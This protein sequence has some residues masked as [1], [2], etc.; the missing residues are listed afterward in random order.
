M[1]AKRIQITRFEL[2]VTRPEHVERFHELAYLN[3]Q[4][5]N[6]LISELLYR[7]RQSHL[8]GEK[9]DL[10]VLESEFAPD[11]LLPARIKR[12]GK[13]NTN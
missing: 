9:A 5:K 2:D 3:M 12:D 13:T 6:R 8:T 7:V 1:A 11:I 4:Y 10:R